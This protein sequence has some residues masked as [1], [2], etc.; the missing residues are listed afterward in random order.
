[1]DDPVSARR[2]AGIRLSGAP[3]FR[4]I[5]GYEAA[6]GR[7][8]RAGNIFRSDSLARLTSQDV[9]ML[10]EL[11]IGTLIDLRSPRERDAYPNRWPERE[12][13]ETLHL[14]ISNDLR[15]AESA[16]SRILSEDLTARGARDVMRETYRRMPRAFV[17]RL[18]HVF[19]RLLAA[20][21]LLVHCTAGKDRTGFVAAMIMSA[22]G[23]DRGAIYEE[24]MLTT[25][26]CDIHRIA[27]GSAKAIA[28]AMGLA[29]IDFDFV[30]V[31]SDVAPDYLD[32]AYSAIDEEFGSID[33]YLLEAGG[34]TPEKHARLKGLLLK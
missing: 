18:N 26:Q 27:K 25:K 1:M 19:D 31:M 12:G 14:D 15:A 7:A 21:P 20:K 30:L 6:D 3:N 9:Q 34:L 22:L 29:E 28:A 24:Y 17:G 13:V 11:G 5:G 16:L 23:I 10:D 32:L 33:S 4:E 2:S 8:M